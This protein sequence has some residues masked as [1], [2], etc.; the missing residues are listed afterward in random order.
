MW[1]KNLFFVL[2]I[3][4]QDHLKLSYAMTWHH[5]K[6]VMAAKHFEDKKTLF[7][8]VVIYV[9]YKESLME[10]LLISPVGMHMKRKVWMNSLLCNTVRASLAAA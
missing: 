8:W 2:T 1:L 5:I 3:D 7:K 10:T 4:H 9:A 6:Y